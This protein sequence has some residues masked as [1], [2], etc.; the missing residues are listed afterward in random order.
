MTTQFHTGI[1]LF[2]YWTLG[3]VSEEELRFSGNLSN[4]VYEDAK[5]ALDLQ[6]EN[7]KIALVSYVSY[8][9]FTILALV[10]N[11]N[12]LPSLSVISTILAVIFVVALLVYLIK[13]YTN[14]SNFYKIIDQKNVINI[15][16]IA[17]IGIPLYFLVYIYYNKKLKE[18]IK[19]IN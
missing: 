5:R 3:G 13:V 4:Q 14:L 7:S 1:L 9:L 8:L 11:N 19:Q 6:N 18:D 2:R 15:L 17:I 12:K 10:F 16:G